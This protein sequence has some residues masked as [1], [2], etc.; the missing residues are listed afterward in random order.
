MFKSS[1]IILSFAFFILIGVL[2]FSNFREHKNKTGSLVFQDTLDNVL[3]F[4]KF[5]ISK[6]GETLNFVF[7]DGFWRLQEKGHYYANLEVLNQ[8]FKSMNSSEY[9]S[10]SHPVQEQHWTIF[11][12]PYD[13]VK[14]GASQGEYTN[15]LI[16]NEHWLVSEYFKLPQKSYSWLQQPLIAINK[17]LIEN[18][19]I[20]DVSYYGLKPNITDAMQYLVFTDVVA[21]KDFDF[22]SN[23]LL[24]KIDVITTAGLI[25]EIKLYSDNWCQVSYSSTSLPNQSVKNFIT[26]QSF[27]VDNWVFKL[28]KSL[29][30]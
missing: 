13:S 30:D 25:I 22:R 19:K 10:K 29:R 24:Q 28:A 2:V 6:D 18:I 17:G 4:K 14:I 1:L 12:T 21:A 16:G 27:L 9:F 3:D 23:N 5:S 26:D 11:K 7:E 15:F 8:L 20:D